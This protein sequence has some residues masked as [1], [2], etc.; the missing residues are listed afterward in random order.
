[1]QKLTE[2][3]FLDLMDLLAYQTTRYTTILAKGGS[4]DQFQACK[5]LIQSVQQE[6]EFRQHS[7]YSKQTSNNSRYEYLQH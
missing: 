4:E 3:E 7:T 1:M 2:F 5:Q 6:L